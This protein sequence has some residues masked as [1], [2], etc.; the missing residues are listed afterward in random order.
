M[1]YC[2]CG[3][4]YYYLVEF[5]KHLKFNEENLILMTIEDKKRFNCTI[6]N[7]CENNDCELFYITDDILPTA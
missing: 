2:L 5:N 7:Y 4:C 6:C 1:I 3:D